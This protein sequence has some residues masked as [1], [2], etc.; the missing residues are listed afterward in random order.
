MRDEYEIEHQHI[1]KRNCEKVTQRAAGSP[2][3]TGSEPTPFF[4]SASILST[5]L[6][7]LKLPNP[8]P[9]PYLPSRSE[10]DLRGS[11]PPKSNRCR[12]P[13][14][15]PVEKDQ[16]FAQPQI[17]EWPGIGRRIATPKE[18][19]IT[20][21]REVRVNQDE[22]AHR[23]AITAAVRNQRVQSCLVEFGTSGWM[24]YCPR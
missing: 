2:S 7:Q 19:S 9:M 4:L 5:C 15:T 21:G 6:P 1:G 14:H 24:P 18:E 16:D 23:T 10:A 11:R 13:Y 22:Q 3:L 17:F 12:D 8:K 20:M